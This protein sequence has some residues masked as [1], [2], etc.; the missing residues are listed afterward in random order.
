MG[1]NQL[2]DWSNDNPIGSNAVARVWDFCLWNIC[3]QAS[4]ICYFGITNTYFVCHWTYHIQVLFKLEVFCIF[5]E[6]C[7][8]VPSVT[9]ELSVNHVISPLCSPLVLTSRTRKQS[10]H[11]DIAGR[12]LFTWY[13]FFIL[14]FQ[15]TCIFCI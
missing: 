8:S 5:T 9:A 6:Q 14:S 12:L 13:T 11:L 15:L 7:I 2:K 1:K 4:H 10:S 3:K